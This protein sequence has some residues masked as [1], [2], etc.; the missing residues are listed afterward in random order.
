MYDLVILDEAKEELRCEVAYSREKW[1][2][3]HGE[4]YA[5]ELQEQIRVLRNNPPF[6]L[7]VTI[8]SQTFVSKHSKAIRS[9]IQYEKIRTAL[10]CWL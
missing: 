5:K 7:C 2:T 9:F 3:T 6:T 1:G 4:K 10:L 8:S